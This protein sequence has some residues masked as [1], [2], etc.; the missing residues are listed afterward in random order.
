MFTLLCFSFSAELFPFLPA[1][2]KRPVLQPICTRPHTSAPYYIR[3][4]N[5]CVR[6]RTYIFAAKLL[7]FFELCKSF[8]EKSITT[9]IIVIFYTFCPMPSIFLHELSNLFCSYF[10]SANA[11]S[12]GAFYRRRDTKK[13]EN[14][15]LLVGTQKH[16]RTNIDILR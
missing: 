13:R 1:P 4:C 12:N 10:P 16:T 7:H 11:P 2:A 3:V 5:R 8:T 9:A 6:T 15:V 14:I